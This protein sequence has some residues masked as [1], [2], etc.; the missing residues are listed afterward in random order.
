MEELST[1]W[2]KLTLSESEE[3]RVALRLDRKK[4]KFV[5]ARKF[6][7][8]R[9][10]NVEAVAKTFKPLWCI[11][12]GFNVTVGGENI[13]LFAFELEVD[14]EKVFQG[15]PC[16]LSVLAKLLDLLLN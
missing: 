12:G 11:K 2:K 16:C 15:E 7:T 10:L 3:N 1:R 9:A 5:L 4:R 6:F 14:A 8:H 13:L